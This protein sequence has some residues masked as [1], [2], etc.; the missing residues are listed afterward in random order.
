MR[1]VA[2][3]GGWKSTRMVEL[4]QQIDAETMLTVVTQPHRLRENRG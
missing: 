4:Y 2:Q 3:A 1:D